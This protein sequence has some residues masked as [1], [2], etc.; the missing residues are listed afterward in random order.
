MNANRVWGLLC[1]YSQP[2]GLPRPSVGR[3]GLASGEVFG[4]SLRFWGS[5]KCTDG[6]FWEIGRY[7]KGLNYSGTGR[8]MPPVPA[9]TPGADRSRVNDLPRAGHRMPFDNCPE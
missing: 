1:L 7:R 3:S 2:G 4:G 9:E 6:G 8:H 5:E